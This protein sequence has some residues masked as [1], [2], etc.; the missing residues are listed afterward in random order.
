MHFGT[1]KNA[2]TFLVRFR[3]HFH[4]FVLN[5][6]DIIDSDDGDG[7]DGNLVMIVIMMTRIILL[8]MMMTQGKSWAWFEGRLPG[9]A[10]LRSQTGS[11]AEEVRKSF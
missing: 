8:V 11:A 5:T 6:Q 10:L 9:A 7:S 3:A 1:Y 4:A 2:L